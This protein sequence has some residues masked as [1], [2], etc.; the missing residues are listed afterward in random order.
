MLGDNSKPSA[1]SKP[2]SRVE[3]EEAFNSEETQGTNNQ[4]VVCMGAASVVVLVPCGRRCLCESRAE[5]YP[6]G[7]PSPVYWAAV[8]TKCTIFLDRPQ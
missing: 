3:D 8:I 7:D 2:M 6:A 5:N 1:D 4:C